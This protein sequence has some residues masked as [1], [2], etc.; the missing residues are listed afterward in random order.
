LDKFTKKLNKLN[1]NNKTFLNP[2]VYAALNVNNSDQDNILKTENKNSIKRSKSHLNIKEKVYTH[3]HTDPLSII[4]QHVKERIKTT[5]Q[6]EEELLNLTRNSNPVHSMN[7]S[8]SS[9]ITHMLPITNLS[10]LSD[11]KYKFF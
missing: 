2:T 5:K 4:K 10:K 11:T 6:N 3:I 9:N 1:E 8:N 7:K